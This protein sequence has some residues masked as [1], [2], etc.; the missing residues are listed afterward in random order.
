MVE[1][2]VRSQ[3]PLHVLSLC[4][5][6]RRPA[7][8]RGSGEVVEGHPLST[9]TFGSSARTRRSP[10]RSSRFAPG[11][12]PPHRHAHTLPAEAEALGLRSIR[13]APRQASRCPQHPPHDVGRGAAAP[14]RRPPARAR[15]SSRGAHPRPAHAPAA[16][17]PG[18]ALRGHAAA[19]NAG[20]QR[21]PWPA[22]PRGQNETQATARLTPPAP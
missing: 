10:G 11:S 4:P 3:C 7:M 14:S 8:G 22:S 13:R 20:I 18:P 9:L 15:S 21:T 17:H 2:W 16:C 1:G 6:C 5:R 12:S 19:L